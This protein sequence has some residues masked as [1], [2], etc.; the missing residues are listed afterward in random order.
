MHEPA[1]SPSRSVLNSANRHGTGFFHQ[2]FDRGFNW[3][4]ASEAVVDIGILARVAAQSWVAYDLTGSSLWV[5]AVAAF[6]AVP[7]FFSPAIAAYIG[8]HVNHRLLVATMRAFIG[9]LAIIQAILIGTGTI[10][11]WHQ[12]ILTLLTGWLG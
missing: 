12:A 8:N 5:G 1:Q 3:V 2:I 6:R 11:P 10:R 4:V 7:S 9:I